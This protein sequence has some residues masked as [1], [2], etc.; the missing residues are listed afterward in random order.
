[1]QNEL[2][3]LQTSIAQRNEHN[4]KSQQNIAD[5]TK[6]R[7][8]IDAL[9]N[10]PTAA[11][12]NK[13][14]A[15]A[16]ELELRSTL[17][18]VE[19]DVNLIRRQSEFYEAE[20]NADVLI[21]SIEV[22]TLK[23][24]TAQQLAEFYESKLSEQR[25]KETQQA[26]NAAQTEVERAPKLLKP[27]AEENARIAGLATEILKPAKAAR[28][29]LKAELIQLDQINKKFEATKNRVNAVGLTASVGAYLRNRK[30]EIPFGG[31]GSSLAD[32]RIGDIE[33]YQS[34]L[35]DLQEQDQTLLADSVV[36]EVLANAKTES[37]N[38]SSEEL[39]D[40]KKATLALVKRRRELLSQAITNCTEYLDTLTN[41]RNTEIALSEETSNFHEYI[42]ER[43]L[44]IRSN[45]V[46]FS[47]FDRDKPDKSDALIYNLTNWTSIV[48]KLAKDA[49]ANVG[50]YVLTAIVFLA[51]F[52]YR[53]TLRKA[54]RENAATVSRGSNTDF[55][56][57]VRTLFFTIAIS[58]MIPLVLF[59]TGWRLVQIQSNSPFLTAF[60]N[61]LINTGWFFLLTEFL[62]QI[63]R[64]CGLAESHFGWCS[65]T[66]AKL[67]S[68]LAWF[69]PLGS[70]LTFVCS[71]LYLVE[72]NHETD[73]LE[74]VVFLI[75]LGTVTCLLYR[76]LHPEKGMLR[77]QIASNP[78]SWWVQ[79]KSIWF[80]GA[81]LIPVVLMAMVIVGYYYSAIQMV[82]RL[83]TTIVVVVG[84]EILRSLLTRYILLSRRKARIDQS[85]ARMM[86]KAEGEADNVQAAELQRA[87]DQEAFLAEASATIDQNVLRSQKLVSAAV[88]IA[89]VISVSFIWA[90][91]FPALRG[92]DKY[93]LWNSSVAV[94]AEYDS[95][96]GISS[97][98]PAG[99]MMAESDT[100]DSNAEAPA[101]SEN[102]S[103]SDE[104]RQ[105]IVAVT[106]RH[107]MMAV[108]ILGVSIFAVQNLPAFLDLMFLKH[109]AVEQSVRHAVKAITGYVILLV[110]VVAAG[111]AM[112]IGW[113]QIQWLATALTFGLAFGLQEI[114]ANFIAGII[115]LLE[116]P[117]RIGDVISVDDV[118]G[119]VSKIRIRA[120]TITDLERKDYIVPNKEFITGRVLNWTLSDKVNRMTISVGVA[121]GSDVRRAQAI[122]REICLSHPLVLDEPKAII[123][124]EE[125][126]DST[127]NLA[128]R[129][130]LKDYESRWPALNEINLAI[131][132]AFK[133]EGIE[134]A[135]PQQDLHIRTASPE[136]ENSVRKTIARE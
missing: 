6:Q 48:G 94:A 128:A 107:L 133:A 84:F 124:F 82:S 40:L 22:W 136:F 61:A 8:A 74:R 55:M 120:T 7:D 67:K 45:E 31:W 112:Y 56:P 70:L 99:R 17:Q 85:R 12:E 106:L 25:Q 118:T 130:Y 46:L 58:S 75:A 105:E 73:F 26:V 76:V 2:R 62:R 19:S 123:T 60:G 3:N 49:M 135:F 122:L 96:S 9:L 4:A 30:T 34:L 86:A 65:T 47:S 90:D 52:G 100:S 115:L 39:S 134:I 117:I 13:L 63:C 91:V 119:T 42:N 104:P 87:T 129:V 121:Y 1:M 103:G 110:G 33:E 80:W 51:L 109:L 77:E 92:L 116:R 83:F 20:Q 28:K 88:V 24:K 21:T 14:V 72:I 10:D 15:E 23:T 78:K 32:E 95:E 98:S 131:D 53:I 44:W 111:R 18:R 41:L 11:P 79:T 50:V 97:M 81:V 132:D 54:I 27:F 57:T 114:F 126:G 108:F 102:A 59:A 35:F 89:W 113:S 38:T 66:V 69:V 5:L 127:L 93:V 36:S 29:Y 37:P 64:E 125:F 101:D 16:W 71:I 43:I 68:E